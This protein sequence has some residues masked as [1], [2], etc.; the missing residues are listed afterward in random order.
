MDPG[1][2]KQGEIMELQLYR[3]QSERGWDAQP[4]PGLDS[5]QTLVVAFGSA[6]TA[7]I[8]EGLL[9]LHNSYP[10]SVMTGCSTAG[11]IYDGELLDG[12]LVAAVAR[13]HGSRVRAACAPL[14][15]ASGSFMA[16][17]DLA[18]ALT[19]PD[20]RGVFVLSEGLNINGTMLIEGLN[21]ILPK[22]VVI[23][24]GLAGDGERFKKTWI[25]SRGEPVSDRVC[26][27]GFYGDAIRLGHGSR[28]GWDLLGPERK[29][30]ASVHNVLYELDG[31]PALDIYKR[32][33][34]ERAKDLPASGLLFPLSIRN[35]H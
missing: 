28:G 24:G 22:G 20:L 26:A 14:A 15:S 16:G 18:S 35:E 31:R 7:A 4:D 13:F 6:D 23:T 21:S 19:S 1:V 34:G 29:V 10:S 32:Y 9:Q 3:Y 2:E 12:S 5:E 25:L 30:T 17:R 11:E 27:V 33:L 8:R